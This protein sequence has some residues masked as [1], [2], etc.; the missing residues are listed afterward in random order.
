MGSLVIIL[1]EYFKYIWTQYLTQ[2]PTLVTA[3][4]AHVLLDR[5]PNFLGC[6]HCDPGLFVIQLKKK[7]F[8]TLEE[9]IIF[10]MEQ[11]FVLKCWF[12]NFPRG[13]HAQ[14]ILSKW[15]WSTADWIYQFCIFPNIF[16]TKAKYY[17]RNFLSSFSTIEE[18][19]VAR[20]LMLI[21]IFQRS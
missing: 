19:R 14:A 1:V 11:K 20:T 10:H 13:T 8:F 21:T 3:R 2:V 17:L 9:I 6:Y 15:I 18:W 4:R 16:V 5:D 7:I 12:W